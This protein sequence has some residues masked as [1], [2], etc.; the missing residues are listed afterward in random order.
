MAHLSIGEV[1]RRSGFPASTIRYYESLG[2]LPKP[3]RISGQ[4]RY[5]TDV[6]HL[7]NAI[8]LAKRAGFTTAELRQLFQAVHD[9]EAPSAAWERFAHDKLKEVDLLIERAHT[10]K[11]LL[12]EG[13]RCGCLGLEECA[14][15]GRERDWEP[16]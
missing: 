4:R 1:S 9:R 11:S 8:G 13:L 6:L 7:L 12:E 16:A 3:E 10:M 15:F 2:I 5:D 14:F